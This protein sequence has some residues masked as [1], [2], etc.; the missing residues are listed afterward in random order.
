MSRKDKKYLPISCICSIYINTILNEF[1]ISLDSILCQKY[2]P[3]EIIIVLDGEISKEV[4]KFIKYI[5]KNEEIFK[6]IKLRQ[7]KGLGLALKKG[8]NV[9]ALTGKNGLQNCEG[10]NVIELKVASNA[11]ARIQEA[12]IFIGHVICEGIELAV[13]LRA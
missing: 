1:I 4:Q 6:I 5:E 11:T 2:I 9:I 10:L 13:N 7:N 12:H 3:N 8:I